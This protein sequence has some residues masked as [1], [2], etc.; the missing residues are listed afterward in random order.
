MKEKPITAI[1]LSGAVSTALAILAA[2]HA[3]PAHAAKLEKCYGVAL[4]G[5][6]DCAA[7]SHE[8]AGQATQDYDPSSFKY[9][10]EGTCAQV[11][12]ALRKAGKK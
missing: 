11:K 8:C 4:A 7:G 3:T 2:Q 1:M 12:A 6:N 9:V 5:Q 10:K